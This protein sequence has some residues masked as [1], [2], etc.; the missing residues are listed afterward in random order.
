MKRVIVLLAVLAV[1]ATGYLSIWGWLPVTP[2]ISSGM[3]PGIHSGSLL[4]T[5]P[6]AAGDIQNGEI[7]VFR[8]SG[9]ARERYNYPPLA[10]SRVTT[11]KGSPSAL[12]F[13]T[14]SDMAGSDPFTVNARDVY[15][16]IKYQIPYLGLPL[17]FLYSGPGTAFVI[18]LMILLAFSLYLNEIKAG[19]GTGFRNFVSPVIKENQRVNIVL[20]NRFRATEKALESFAGAM[21]EYAGHMASHT[22][23]IKGLSEASQALKDSAAEQNRILAHF[24]HT[25]EIEKSVREVSQVK[26]VVSE[27]EKRT[28]MALLV[29][30]EIEGK[31]PV[32]RQEMP[33]EIPPPTGD[34]IE[35]KPPAAQ[36]QAPREVPPPAKTPSPPG[37]K[38][39]ARALNAI[40]ISPGHPL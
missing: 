3:E 38:V 34:K 7:I 16:A 18:I 30:D 4:L 33:G 21:H 27:L 12:Q 2:V 23:A 28:R 10:I 19:L 22:S 8:T 6:V 15:G 36:Q 9:L 40:T 24:T 31:T 5:S 17:V 39:N 29:K 32:M 14:A 1:L 11:V 35:S 37:C 26:R 20:S 13:Q 25:L